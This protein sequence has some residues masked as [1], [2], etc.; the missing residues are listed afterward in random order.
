MHEVAEPA[1]RA[2]AHFILPATGFSEVGDWRKFGVNGQSIVPPVV[3]ICHGFGSVFFLAELDVHVAHQMIAQIVADVHLLHFSVF[4]FHFE[5][6]I[7]EK[8]IVV[9]LLFDVGDRGSRFRRRCRVLQVTITILEDDGLRE[10]G[11]VVETG[12]GRSVTTSSDFD[13]KRT[14]D[15]VL[16]RPENRGQ[17]FSHGLYVSVWPLS[18]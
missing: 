16:F 7:F 12:A 6:D 11:F 4:V 9:L 3:Q 8:V 10:G 15:F 14:V 13:V 2:F 5:E 17:I 18:L 1:S